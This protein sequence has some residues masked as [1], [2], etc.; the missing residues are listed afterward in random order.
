[1]GIE[2]AG[3]PHRRS[4][5]AES[6]MAASLGVQLDQI[7]TIPTPERMWKSI[8]MGY[9]LSNSRADVLS[10][11]CAVARSCPWQAYSRSQDGEVLQPAMTS[12]PTQAMATLRQEEKRAGVRITA[13]LET[14]A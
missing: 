1:L 4:A 7:G 12:A 10:A 5:G 8:S 3:H 14:Q 13:M 6:D 9:D 2:I 11:T